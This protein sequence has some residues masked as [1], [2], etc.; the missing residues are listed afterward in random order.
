[1]VIL[2]EDLERGERLVAA[3]LPF[4]LG[5]DVVPAARTVEQRDDLHQ[6]VALEDIFVVLGEQVDAFAID[7]L[8]M[9]F[10]LEL[11]PDDH[12]AWYLPTDG[13]SPP[14]TAPGRRVP[15]ARSAIGRRSVMNW[16][17]RSCRTF[18]ESPPSRSSRRCRS[19][20]QGRTLR[21]R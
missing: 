13:F 9:I 11:R 6:I 1:M 12:R 7:R 2:P 3:D 10:A 16:R 17:R 20:K 4:D 15:A 5:E 19:P 8:D 18:P 21:D 14:C